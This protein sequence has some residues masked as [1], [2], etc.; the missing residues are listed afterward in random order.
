MTEA[1]DLR[2]YDVVCDA[3][4]ANWLDLRETGIGASEIASVFGVSPWMSALA[5]YA[6]KIGAYER[7]FTEVEAVYWGHKL[8]DDIVDGYQERTGRPTRRAGK[9]L[10]SRSHPWAMCTLDGE[11]T[12][13]AND[14][15]WWPFEAKN[16]T[17]FKAS[18]WEGGAPEHYRLQC[19]QQMLVTGEQKAT[20]A[21]LLG[22]NRLV[23]QD[24]HRDEDEIRRI[25]YHGERFWKR[26]QAR[27]IPMPDGSESSRKALNALYPDGSGSLVLPRTAADAAD[28]L[29]ELKAQIKRLTD[30]REAIENTVKLAL[31]ETEIGHLPDGRSFSWKLQHRKECVVKASSFRVLRLHQPK[32]R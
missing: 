3:T 14:S 30:E 32:N 12:A 11:T 25:I 19:M 1:I 27:D 18:E 6:S 5:L 13:A 21:A 20:I 7:D 8:E 10:R 26:I 4:D 9:L 2:P 15:H 22:G 23:W 28:R 16:V 29:D 31:G 17:I 24:V